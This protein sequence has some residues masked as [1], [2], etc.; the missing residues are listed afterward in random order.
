MS[1]DEKKE[2][3][4]GENSKAALRC[5]ATGSWQYAVGTMH[6]FG[7]DVDGAEQVFERLWFL[8]WGSTQNTP[9][10]IGNVRTTP[11]ATAM[12]LDLVARGRALRYCA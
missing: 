3:F 6:D 5:P 11:A 2:N 9:F 8:L 10:L 7:S 1:A 4:Q 12:Y